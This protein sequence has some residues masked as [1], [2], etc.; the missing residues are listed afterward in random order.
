VAGGWGAKEVWAP[1]KTGH[2]VMLNADW[3]A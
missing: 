1:A 3:M 2:N